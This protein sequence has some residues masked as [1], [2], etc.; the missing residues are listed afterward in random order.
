MVKAR[1]IIHVDM[2]AFYASVEQLDRPELR[3]RPVIVGGTV[4]NRGVVSAAS[5]EARPFG[6]HSAMPMARALRR[7]PEAIVLPVRMDRYIAV[8]QQ[9]REVFTHYTPL[10]EPLSLDEAFLDVTDSVNLFGAAEQI[11]RAIKQQIKT[12]TGLTASVGLATNKFLAK[13]ASDLEKPDGFVVIRE[14]NKQRIL[15]GLA[16][17]RIWGVG[18]ITERALRAHSICTI[19]DLRRCRPE[20]LRTIVG[21]ATDELLRLAQGQDDRPVE[22]DRRRKSL[23][24]EQTFARD[25][26]NETVL[27][28]VLLEQVEEVAQRLRQ[29]RVRAR[30][31]TL[32]LRYGDFRTLTRSETLGEATNLTALLW[33]A[34]ERVF[35][36]WHRRSGGALR[37]L[38]FGASGLT[39][40]GTAQETLFP[41]PEIEKLRRLDQ[42]VDAIRDRYGKHSLHRGAEVQSP[43]ANDRPNPRATPRM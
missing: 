5:Y 2:D 7:C 32:K 14:E 27:L 35:R 1:Q 31:I 3:G 4:E 11:G 9:I 10:V 39:P 41:D 6:V 17:S 42:T 23:S 21:N 28:S 22:P 30:T 20:E 43:H 25:V 36:Q 15:D 13:L 33:E 18:R 34:A 40:E 8:S 26:S 38:G 37:L 29:C 24:S 19:A 16:V 12:Y